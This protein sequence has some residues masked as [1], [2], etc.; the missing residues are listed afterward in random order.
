MALPRVQQDDHHFGT[1]DEG[2]SFQFQPSASRFKKAEKIESI[3]RAEKLKI[4][5]D[6]IEKDLNSHFCSNRK[7][8]RIEHSVMAKFNRKLTNSRELERTSLLKQLATIHISVVNIQNRLKDVTPTPKFVEKIKIMMTDTENAIDA[9][10]EK[11]RLRYEDLIR[12]EKTL[13]KELNVLNRKIEMWS[14]DNSG[15]GKALRGPSSK[16]SID[17]GMQNNLPKE[18]VKFEK[19]LQHTG[20]RQGGWDVDDHQTFMKVKTKHRR[21]TS[22]IEEVLEYLPGKTREDVQQHETWYQEYLLLERSKKESIQKWKAEKQLKREEIL[23]P[24][25]VLKIDKTQQELVQKQKEEAREKQKMAVEAW[26]R[27]KMVEMAMKHDLQFK[28]EEKH[29]R[30]QQKDRQSQLQVKQLLEKYTEKKKQ[31]EFLRHEKEMRKKSEKEARRK[32][33]VDEISKFQE[34]DLHK[35]EFKMLVKQAKEEEKAERERRLSKLR[36]KVEV[37][38]SRDPSRLHRLTKGW[39][40]KVKEKR[41]VNE[42][43]LM[44]I[45]HRAVPTWRQGL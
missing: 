1:T 12:E 9:F 11:Q 27:Q 24:K 37:N 29:K 8:F 5:I 44:T 25:K 33:S 36:Q 20:G 42:G 17:K 15:A 10:K 28:E 19:F 41:P 30:K 40:E 14:L 32:S 45:P 16:V 6:N 26:K 4:L 22:Y 7:N 31:E 39:E 38:V 13:T 34:R 18:V 2:Q 3:R 43:P 23:K 21:K 35:H